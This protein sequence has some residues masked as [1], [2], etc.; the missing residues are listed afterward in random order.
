[1][2]HHSD[3][4]YLYF[5][6]GM[7]LATFSVLAS[8]IGRRAATTRTSLSFASIVIEI[9]YVGMYMDFVNRVSVV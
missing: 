7:W 4:G 1:M 2:M 3:V 6:I 8:V 5:C 9:T